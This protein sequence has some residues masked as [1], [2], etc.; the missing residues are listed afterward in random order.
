MT[1]TTS[2]VDA[3]FMRPPSMR[4]STNVPSPT[5]VIEAR[6]AG[7]RLAVEMGHHA[8][9]EAVGLDPPVERERAQRRD[10]PPVRPDRAPDQ[11][12]AREVVEPAGAAVA[13]SRG[14]HERQVA[15]AAGFA[16]ARLERDDELLG[17]GDPD[18]STDGQRVTVEDQPGGRLGRDD[19]RAPPSRHGAT[20]S[21]P[22]TRVRGRRTSRRTSGKHRGVGSQK[23]ALAMAYKLL[24]AAQERWRRV[25]GH[26]LVA[27]VL[28]TVKFKDGIRITEDDT[29]HDEMTDE[30]VAAERL[31]ESS[32]TFDSSSK[33]FAVPYRRFRDA[34]RTARCGP[35]RRVVW[36]G[37]G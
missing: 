4:G 37:P 14:E 15:R 23:A 7:G 17:N 18:E 5:R 30:K 20:L 16:E 34:E 10:E 28:D 33:G 31:H 35:A 1:R 2:S 11:P 19:L 6:P 25:N 32:T 13:L 36:E 3:A 22:R 8:L 12:L 26:E 21:H 27:D 29:N 24:A 9:R